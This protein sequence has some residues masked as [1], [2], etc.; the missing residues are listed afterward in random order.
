[1]I[2][3]SG[4][5]L[6]FNISDLIS[7]SMSI[8]GLVGAFVLLGLAFHFSKELMWIISTAIFTHKA[9]AEYNKEHAEK[10]GKH[11]IKDTI[12]STYQSGKYK[13]WGR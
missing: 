8:F 3:F 1:M 12:K 5:I 2:D 10:F 9:G 11:T 7:S 4:I 13:R 6:P